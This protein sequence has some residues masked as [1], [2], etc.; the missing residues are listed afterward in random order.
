MPANL[1]ERY[2]YFTQADT[3]KLRQTGYTRPITP[4]A[5]AVQDYVRHHLATG[6]RLGE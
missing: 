1:R 6:K 5:D 3:T 4:L 2:Q